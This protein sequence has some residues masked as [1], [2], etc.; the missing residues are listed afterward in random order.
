MSQLRELTAGQADQIHSVVQFK[1]CPDCSQFRL[2]SVQAVSVK[3]DNKGKIETSSKDVAQDYV[4]SNAEYTRLMNDLE[5]AARS[6]P[7][8]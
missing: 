4:L 3:K 2:I 8:G 5:E 6:S 7:A 1:A